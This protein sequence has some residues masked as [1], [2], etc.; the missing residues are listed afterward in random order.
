MFE[1]LQL[2]AVS[3]ITIGVVTEIII[4]L[5]TQGVELAKTVL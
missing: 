5:F 3:G 2:F 4:P 1:V